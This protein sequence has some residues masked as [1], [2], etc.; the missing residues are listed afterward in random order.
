MTRT[1]LHE[2]ESDTGPWFLVDERVAAQGGSNVG[3]VY[4]RSIGGSDKVECRFDIFWAC[5]DHIRGRGRPNS[6]QVR[7]NVGRSRIWPRGSRMAPRSPSTA[8]R[9][10]PPSLAESGSQPV[11]FGP[12]LVGIGT[13]LPAQDWS[14]AARNFARH[15]PDLGRLLPRL[16]RLRPKLGRNLA[17]VGSTL[18]VEHLPKE[19]WGPRTSAD[20]PPAAMCP[21]G[22]GGPMACAQ[23]AW[24]WASPPLPEDLPWGAVRRRA[25]PRSRTPGGRGIASCLSRFG[26]LGG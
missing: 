1:R 22:F 20:P 3:G 7:P 25:R 8:G 11:D 24:R 18:G 23:C 26:I 10:R 21:G 17:E 12:H 4:C 6:D 15:R 9:V 13:T 19:A 16:G 2:F 14:N 5:F